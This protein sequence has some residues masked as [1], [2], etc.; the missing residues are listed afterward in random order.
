MA[1]LEAMAVGLPV[2]AWDLPVYRE[3]FP[4][5]LVRVPVGDRRG[6]VEA[7]LSLL[8]DERL[9]MSIVVEASNLPATY[10]WHLVAARERQLIQELDMIHSPVGRV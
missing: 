10:D 4:I 2:V 6:F 1:V 8:G 5:G 9:A 7:V 3:V